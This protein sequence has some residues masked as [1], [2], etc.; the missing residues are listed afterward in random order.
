[1]LS[2]CS[3]MIVMIRKVFPALFQLSHTCKVKGAWIYLK[4]EPG[5]GRVFPGA[6]FTH[7][8]G[9]DEN[10]LVYFVCYSLAFEKDDFPK[11]L[12]PGYP[13]SMEVRR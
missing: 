13:G 4:L 8:M 9:V 12:N 1:M 10:S 5:E 6:D 7:L 11:D 3:R 2:G